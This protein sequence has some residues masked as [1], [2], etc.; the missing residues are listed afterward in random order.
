VN[1]VV[2][3]DFSSPECYLASRRVDAL[4]AAGVVVEW[5]AVEGAPL[6]PVSG[7]RLAADEQSAVA[8]RFRALNRLLLPGETLP[9]SM[10][11]IVPKTQAAV[12][13]Y[14]EADAGG[15]GDD[16]RRLLLDMYWLRGRDIGSPTVLRTPLTGPMLRAR[17]EAA[18]L[19]ESGYAVNVDRGPITTAACLRIRDWRGEWQML[20]SLRMPVL[21]IGGA[22]LGGVD[23]VRRLGKE[24][25]YAGAAAAPEPDDPRRYPQVSVRPSAAWVSQIGG[26]WRN[27][28]RLS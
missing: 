10:P 16:V 24:I 19:R 6:L 15:V 14:A 23:A 22:T 26:R 3:A 17:S 1:L 5:R 8:D 25:T 28:Y 21:L 4:G 11:T 27:V 12:S 7:R 13:A 2:Y 20:G 18:P 9:W